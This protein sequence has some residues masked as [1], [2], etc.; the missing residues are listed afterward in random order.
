[1]GEET[2]AYGHLLLELRL[3][4]QQQLFWAEVNSNPFMFNA[5]APTACNTQTV[6]YA[7]VAFHFSFQNTAMCEIKGSLSGR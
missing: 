6:A 4:G 7:F 5:I 1:M 3:I 2:D